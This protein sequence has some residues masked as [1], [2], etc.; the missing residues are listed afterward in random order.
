M[1]QFP[2]TTESEPS[3]MPKV[4]FAV[5]LLAG[6]MLLFQ[7][8]PLVQKLFEPR[9]IQ[10]CARSAAGKTRTISTQTHSPR[11]SPGLYVF[12]NSPP[13]RSSISSVLSDSKKCKS[14][15]PRSPWSNDRDVL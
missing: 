5:P 12:M 14:P 4:T 8:A 3:D 1:L 7:L 10:T 6:G 15:M 13:Q 9:P 2:F 11:P